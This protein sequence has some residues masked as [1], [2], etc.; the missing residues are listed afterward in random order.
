MARKSGSFFLYLI[1]ALASFAAVYYFLRFKALKNDLELGRAQALSLKAAEMSTFIER[2][3]AV[4]S[5]IIDGNYNGAKLAYEELLDQIPE[6]EDFNSAIELRMK[7]LKKYSS[8]RQKLWNYETQEPYQEFAE[9]IAAKNHQNDSL[10]KR[11]STLKGDQKDQ[12]DSLIFALEKAY[13]R[14]KSLSGQ[15]SQKPK[16]G[17]LDFTGAKG[18]SIYYV[19]ELKDGKAY[20]EGIAMYSDGSRYEGNWENNQRHGEG[21]FYWPDGEYYKG[22]YKKDQRH[23]MGNYYWPN[24]DMFSGEWK[25]DKRNGEGTFY[26]KDG[27]TVNGLWKNNKLVDREK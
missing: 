10:S 12:V 24:G 19:G 17:H 8:M 11:L 21:T 9:I 4:D 7:S 5:L 14:A 20:G 3:S 15:L 18:V 22:S 27:K 1:L 16:N 6:N 13:S 2:L 25:K 23:G 26:G